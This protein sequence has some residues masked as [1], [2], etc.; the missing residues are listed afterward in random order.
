MHLRSLESKKSVKEEPIN[1]DVSYQLGYQA[2]CHDIERF[3]SEDPCPSKEKLMQLLS[4]K[5][6]SAASAAVVAPVTR[7]PDGRLALI[8]MSDSTVTPPSS[9]AQAPQQP[10]LLDPPVNNNMSS[11]WRPWF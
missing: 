8:L 4:R 10:V 1:K 7:L 5:S 11:V 6:E 9:P 2:C 3:L